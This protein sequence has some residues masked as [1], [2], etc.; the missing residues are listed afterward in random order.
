M[1]SYFRL[2]QYKT[3]IQLIIMSV[4]LPSFLNPNV[5]IAEEQA[6]DH[7]KD[8]INVIVATDNQ[9]RTYFAY[10]N[11]NTFELPAWFFQ[12][13]N[14]NGEF[15]ISS[16]TKHYILPHDCTNFMKEMARIDY[17]NKHVSSM[18]EINEIQYLDNLCI[19]SLGINSDE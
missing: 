10:P 6:R 15:G 4:A 2:W 7:W 1:W 8:P 13:I 19:S 17:Y 9:K 14:G 3:P 5:C 16:P 12:R 11:K 18:S